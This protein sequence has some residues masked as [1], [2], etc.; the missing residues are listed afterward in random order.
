MSIRSVAIATLLLAFLFEF[1]KAQ[2][3]ARQM[4]SMDEWSALEISLKDVKS[5]QPKNGF[6]PDESTAAKIGEAASLAQYGE[7]RI[8]G[9]KPFHAKLYGDTWVVKGTLHPRGAFGG[10]AVVKV[11]RKDGKILFMTHQE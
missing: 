10:T 11:R 5:I 8:S 9:E 6:V 2:Q 3:P 4:D 1:G 7:K